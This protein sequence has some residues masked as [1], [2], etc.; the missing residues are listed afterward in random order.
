MATLLASF[1]LAQNA[2][3]DKYVNGYQKSDGTY[4]Q[5]YHRSDPNDSQSDNYSSKGNVNPYTG[6]KGYKDPND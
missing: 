5:P 6:K 3:A 1:L 2:H 4:V